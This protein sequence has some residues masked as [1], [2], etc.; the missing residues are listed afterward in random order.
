MVQVCSRTTRTI[1]TQG[2]ERQQQ[3]ENWHAQALKNQPTFL[4]YLANVLQSIASFFDL[5][6]P[7]DSLQAFGMLKA[8]HSNTS[9]LKIK[10]KNTSLFSYN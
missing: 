5:Y 6:L 10:R 1:N 9:Y 3:R 4:L 2:N 7:K 8:K